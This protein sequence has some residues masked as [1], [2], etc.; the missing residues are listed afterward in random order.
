MTKQ[1]I[2]ICKTLSKVI[3]NLYL[4]GKISFADEAFNHL[5]IIM[6][7]ELKLNTVESYIIILLLLSCMDKI[8]MIL[9]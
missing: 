2:I 1:N 7:Q 9:A 5:Q 3:A 8:E 4:Y 6:N